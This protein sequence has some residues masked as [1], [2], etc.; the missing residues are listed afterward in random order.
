MYQKKALMRADIKEHERGR[1][2]PMC[3]AMSISRIDLE[4]AF[5]FIT[6]ILYIFYLVDRHLFFDGID[7]FFFSFFFIFFSYFFSL[8]FT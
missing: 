6:A 8:S 2:R 4:C 5:H 1:E 7:H 3:V